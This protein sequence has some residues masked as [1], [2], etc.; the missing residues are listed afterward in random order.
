NSWAY[1]TPTAEQ[2]LVTDLAERSITYGI[3]AVI[4]DGTDVCQV[5]DASWEACERA[6]RGEGPTIIEA[7][8]M[9][10]KRHAIHDAAQYVPSALVQYWQ[11]RD[12]IARFEDYLVRVK[13]WLT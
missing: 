2:Y 5:Y 4:V 10:L 9:R 7:K 3:P 12:P 6:R 11:R 1:S 13:K 8:M